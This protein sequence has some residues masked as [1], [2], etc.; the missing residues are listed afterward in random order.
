MNTKEI[1]N[2][3]VKA[4]QRGYDEG[5]EDTKNLVKQLFLEIIEKVFTKKK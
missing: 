4:Y 1:V 3:A 5:M 2:E